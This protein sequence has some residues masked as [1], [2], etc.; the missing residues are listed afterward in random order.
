MN[1]IQ[2]YLIANM[3]VGT[4]YTF[5]GAAAFFDCESHATQVWIGRRVLIQAACLLWA[6]VL[7]FG[8]FERAHAAQGE[9][10]GTYGG[11]IDFEYPAPIF[12]VQKGGLL[13]EFWDDGEFTNFVFAGELYSIQHPNVRQVSFDNKFCRFGMIVD[14]DPIFH[15]HFDGPRPPKK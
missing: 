1:G 6:L 2:I 8:T 9:C 12:L 13:T 4:W 5:S 15:G 7:F 3:V 14:A 11:V 10:N